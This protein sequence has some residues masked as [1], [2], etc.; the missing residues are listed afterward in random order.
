[1]ELNL[2][3]TLFSKLNLN[4]GHLDDLEIEILEML[5]NNETKPTITSE[6]ETRTI[7]LLAQLIQNI[8]SQ[9]LTQQ[10]DRATYNQL[11]L[12]LNYYYNTLLTYSS[13]NRIKLLDEF[14]C[15]LFLLDQYI[16]KFNSVKNN[17]QAPEDYQCFKFIKS[18]LIALINMIV[19]HNKEAQDRVR[20][21]KALPL[22][23]NQCNIDDNN[24]YIREHSIFAIK[25]LVYNNIEN[26]MWLDQLKPK[27]AAKHPVLEE[28]GIQHDLDQDG[29]L[30]FKQRKKE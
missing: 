3:E 13:E 15:L 23:L 5:N 22:I 14:I 1:M 17:T 29:K 4:S 6:S 28:L 27:E 8:E 21:L 9:L 2:I 10:Q 25:N 26:S 11:L 18:K 19:F 24:P 16:S 7:Q 12:W 30:S 20:E